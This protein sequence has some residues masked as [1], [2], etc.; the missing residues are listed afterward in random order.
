MPR[1][2][3]PAADTT[4]MVQ[5]QTQVQQMLEMLVMS[6]IMGFKSCVCLL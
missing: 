4:E 5:T 6:E 2:K 1:M 3:Y